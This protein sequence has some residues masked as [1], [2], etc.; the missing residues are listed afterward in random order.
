LLLIQPLVGGVA[1]GCI[2]GLVAMGI[3]LI[4]QARQTV[5]L[6]QGEFMLLAPW[7]ALVGVALL[8]MP[9]W[10]ATCAAVLVVAAFGWLMERLVVRPLALRPG[11]MITLST[12]GAAFGARQLA[13]GL[14]SSHLS[15]TVLESPYTPA[16]WVLAGQPVSTAHLG[17]IA[18]A[19]LVCGAL[20]A[21]FRFS[22]VGFG[23]Q[24]TLR[25]RSAAHHMGLPVRRLESVA[26]ILAAMLAATG[27]LLLA[28]WTP[29]DANMALVGFKALPA[30]L[31][32][33][34]MGL[35]SAML[36]GIFLGVFEAVAN[37]VLPQAWHHSA[38]FAVALV[39]W[40][41]QRSR[42]HE[43]ITPSY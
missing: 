31:L 26:W 9:Y 16:Q 33:S 2:Y 38:V 32:A 35:R 10:L 1:Q 7:A 24:A 34:F 29:V 13:T 37:T 40:V 8:G 41:I 18:V 42:A 14:T 17:A 19:A 12:V 6:A 30:A 5:S 36:G 3:V 4:F 23:L 21:L 22:K 11:W 20:Y 28:T 25:N 39:I 43:P 15:G 27:G